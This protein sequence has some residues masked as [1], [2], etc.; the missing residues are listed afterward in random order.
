[1]P[2]VI[3]RLVKQLYI[4]AKAVRLYPAASNIPK[5]RAAALLA[6]LR[7]AQQR[8][9]DVSLYFA[10]DGVYYGDDKVFADLDAYVQFAREFYNRNIDEVR[11]HVGLTSEDAL[12]FLSLLLI[13]PAELNDAGGSEQRLWDLGVSEVTVKE[14]A[15]RV[16][17]ADSSVLNTA[18]DAV[19]DVPWPP[20][21]EE[22]DQAVA[23]TASHRPGSHRVLM[24]VLL[25]DGVVG[26]YL[27]GSL[28]SRGVT[29]PDALVAG[30]VS[31]LANAIAGEPPEDRQQLLRS[32]AEAL[33]ALPGPDRRAVLV[34]RLLPAARHD[35]AIAAIIQAMTPEEISEIVAMAMLE[36]PDE[37]AEESA[38]AGAARAMHN[39]LMIGGHDRA[40]LESAMRRALGNAGA[41]DDFIGSVLADAMPSRVAV[42]EPRRV[43]DPSVATAVQIVELVGRRSTVDG[44]SDDPEIEALRAEALVGT[45]D[46][47]VLGTLVEVAT[48]ERR[49]DAFDNAVAV[50]EDT[51]HMLLQSQNF[52][53][54]AEAADA[55][56]EASEDESR[57]DDQRERLANLLATLT[58]RESIAQVAS[59]VRL[60]PP[61]SPEQA[62][63]RRLL[64]RLGMVSM[65]RVL[66]ALAEEQ[67]MVTR[68]ALVDALADVAP[69][70]TEQLSRRV[71][72]PRWYVVRNVVILLGRTKDPAALPALTRA[73]RYPEP[74][75]RRE[76]IRALDATPDP[77]AQ[78]LVVSALSDDDAGNVQLAARLLGV[79]R[80]EPA[81][82]ALEEVAAGEGRGSRDVG[83]R[84]EA[85]EALGRIGAPRSEQLLESLV[86]FRGLRSLGRTRELVPAAERA[87]ATLRARRDAPR[88]AQ[89]ATAPP[90][91]APP[92]AAPPATPPPDGG[93]EEPTS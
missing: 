35:P 49:T 81:V 31:A 76:A 52:T 8:I 55:L 85:I 79:R 32:V 53:T 28:V 90:T 50:L 80:Y 30:R 14:I 40:E 86:R 73:A 34:D 4:T 10:R 6:V 92:A 64:E 7:T 18:E 83:P 37:A 16:V 87:L 41:D 84:V 57:P 56:A 89:A 26:E 39:L 54:A 27:R 45:D 13:D 19:D 62:A 65:D 91:V 24:R 42:P 74:R 3:E 88:R 15:A 46:A 93:T 71:N 70:F 29:P 20:T 43:V 12:K 82:P 58:D 63:C 61:G 48:Q 69:R 23:G 44:A 38:R 68:K 11:F 59:A 2:A 51:F 9:P 1:V 47:D 75:V 60:Y 67:D 21:A 5:E 25:D 77:R 66:E 17:D 78:V 36:A 22:I 33:V 72:D